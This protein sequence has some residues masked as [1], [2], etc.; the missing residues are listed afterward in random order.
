MKAEKRVKSD[1]YILKIVYSG[2]FVALGILLPQAF[3]VFGQ[4]AGRM[5]LPI[6][7]PVLMAGLVLG[8]EC[9]GIVGMLVPVLSSV[10]T[11]MPPV[12][13]V[14]FMLFELVPYGVFTG[15]F[16]RKY[17]VYISLVLAMLLGRVCY[18]LA[19]AGGVYILGLHAPFAN[20]AAFVSGVITGIP[21]MCIQ[22]ILIPMLYIALKKGGYIFE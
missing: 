14:Y 17:N 10:L 13:L 3:H 22:I 4:D 21:G 1:H 18:G 19:L 16:I 5:F 11:G 12:P 8:A 9:G 20:G 7:L 2:V 15:I 6:H